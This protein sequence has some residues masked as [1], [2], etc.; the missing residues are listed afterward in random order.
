MDHGLDLF[1]Q[2]KLSSPDFGRSSCKLQASQTPFFWSSFHLLFRLF[3]SILLFLLDSRFFVKTTIAS[4]PP[5][6]SSLTTS[7]LRINSIRF[8]KS[9]VSSLFVVDG[10]I[11][12][13]STMSVQFRSTRK[14]ECS[15]VR[16]LFSVYEIFFNEKKNRWARLWELA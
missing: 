8:K 5:L 13:T 9:E 12:S 4:Q 16:I 6:F 15:C 11:A 7:T 10:V 1:I 3:I 2:Q 14:W